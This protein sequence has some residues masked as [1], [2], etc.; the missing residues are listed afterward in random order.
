MLAYGELRLLPVE[1]TNGYRFLSQKSS[2]VL[3]K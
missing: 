3:F 1:H 2:I